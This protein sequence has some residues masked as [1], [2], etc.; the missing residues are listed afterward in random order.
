MSSNKFEIPSTLVD[1]EFDIEDDKSNK[2]KQ[3][4][5]LIHNIVIWI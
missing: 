2:F 1:D 4:N 3:V 5:Y